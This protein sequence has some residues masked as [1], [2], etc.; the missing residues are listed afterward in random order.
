MATF[1][2]DRAPC[3]AI[4]Q[5]GEDGLHTDFGVMFLPTEKQIVFWP[6]YPGEAEARTVVL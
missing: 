6:G 5:Q 4:C 1:L 2:S 3:G